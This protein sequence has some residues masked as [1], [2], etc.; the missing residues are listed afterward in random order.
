MLNLFQTHLDRI[1]TALMVGDYGAYR[2][3]FDSPLVVL[4]DKET[5]IIATEADFETAFE[6]FHTRLQTERATDLYRLGHAVSQY[7]PDV[8]T[9]R[10][11]SHILR[12]GQRLY[13]P[14]PSAMTLRCV[15]GAWKTSSLVN[16]TFA[17]L[18]PGYG[19]LSN[20]DRKD[21]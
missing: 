10:Y 16:P 15:A 8:L 19:R 13:G 9:G 7:G 6:R 11:E 1:S 14:I 2:A 17:N 3:G 12:N 21:N 20:P 18:W 5:L 4:T